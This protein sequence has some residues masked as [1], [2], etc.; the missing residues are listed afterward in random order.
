MLRSR[1][2]PCL[3]AIA[4]LLSSCGSGSP[5]APP[6]PPL[7]AP[8]ISA[9]PTSQS[10][11][12]GLSAGFAVTATGPELQFQWM[13]NGAPIAGATGSTY[14]TGATAFADSGASFTVAV[15]NSTATVRSNAAVLTVTARA[16]KK[17]DL[18]FGQLDA[19]STVNG[20]GNAGPGLG[21]DLPGRSASYYSP[22]LGTPFY[23]GS[24]GN[25]AIPPVTNGTGCAWLYSTF[26]YT[27][28]STSSA[29]TS[30]YGG[31]DYS[32]FAADL[33]NPSWPSFNN[34]ISAA[35]SGS[36]I[37]SLD[38][39]AADALFAVSWNQS[40]QPGFLMQQN[41][42][43]PADLQAAATQDGMTGRV[44][45]AISN[46]NG[47]ITYLSYA[48]QSDS[49]TAF[50]AK[51]V[52]AAPPDAPTA[53]ADLA[54]QGYILTATGSA[55]GNGNVI[56]VGTRVMGDTMPRPFLSAQSSQQFQTLQQEGYAI[57]AVIFD[58]ANT[59]NPFTYLGER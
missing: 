59:A 40:Q 14:A 18:R 49:V 51:V 50:E 37:N 21:T 27:V 42:V 2:S 58:A 20:W 8:A 52:T 16:P 32:N 3:A 44:I 28:S 24:N 45:T 41:T 15:S 25:C 38:L 12:M 10:V 57:V 54:A 5:G 23:V 36:V 13:R 47:Q 7:A 53:A 39:E 1:S 33:Q 29:V 4:L 26:P 22:S 31:D 19:D 46:D 9:Q 11:P 48:W 17:G 35:A 43:A 56:L 6:P 34:G 55:D 30:G